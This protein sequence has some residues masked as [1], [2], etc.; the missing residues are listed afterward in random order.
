MTWVHALYH[1]PQIMC[2]IGWHKVVLFDAHH[3]QVAQFCVRNP[4]RWLA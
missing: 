2:Q 1:V 4:A 3:H